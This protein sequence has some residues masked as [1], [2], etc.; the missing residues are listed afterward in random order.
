MFNKILR[1]LLT[2]L[3]HTNAIACGPDD[4][5]PHDEI[6]KGEFLFPKTLK[7]EEDTYRTKDGRACFDFHFKDVSGHYEIYVLSSP[8][9][10]YCAE[11]PQRAFC[12]LPDGQINLIDLNCTMAIRTYNQARKVAVVWAEKAWQKLLQTQI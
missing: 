9:S 4:C 10:R 6:G 8:L 12:T 3:D 7:L 1:M 11:N 5:G 2:S